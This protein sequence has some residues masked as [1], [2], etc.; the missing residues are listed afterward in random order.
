[1]HVPN[2]V[3][4]CDTV[5]SNI[6]NIYKN[7]NQSQ[8]QQQK[9]QQHQLSTTNSD[10]NDTNDDDDDDDDG[11]DE[12]VPILCEACGLPLVKPRTVLF[13]RNVPPRF[14]ECA[15]KDIPTLHL[16]IIAG[17]SL[18]VSP[19][20]SLVSAVSDTTVR[21]VINK[22]PVGADLGIV[23]DRHSSNTTGSYNAASSGWGG[24]VYNRDL[25]LQGDCN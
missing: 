9:K 23:Y 18:V 11:P 19:A 10:K 24:G 14:F 3:A 15:K 6:K 8:S 16:L 13:G 2:Y 25:F 20:N 22:E 12:S 1:M 21:V 17:T 5:R 4:F 7:Q